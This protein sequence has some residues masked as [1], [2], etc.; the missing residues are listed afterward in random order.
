M[1]KKVL[2]E[3]GKYLQVSNRIRCGQCSMLTR[4]QTPESAHVLES[5]KEG[6]FGDHA[7]KDVMEVAN[8]PL[9]TAHN[10]EDMFVCDPSAKHYGYKSWDGEFATRVAPGSRLPG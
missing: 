8:A 7:K 2:N 1:L 6:W 5:H 3:W 4:D 9:K 10:F